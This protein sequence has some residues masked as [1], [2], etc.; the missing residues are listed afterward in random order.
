MC[1][2][3]DLQYLASHHVKKTCLKMATQAPFLTKHIFRL[4]ETEYEFQSTK[5]P[6]AEGIEATST[7]V[8]F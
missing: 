2:G 1:L 3:E 6:F 4:S 8:A 7:P 5:F